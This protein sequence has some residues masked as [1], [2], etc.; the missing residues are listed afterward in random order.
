[1]K[2]IDINKIVL[3]PEKIIALSKEINEL[4]DELAKKGI[5]ELEDDE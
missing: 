2:K 4:L 5:I 1:M 3:M